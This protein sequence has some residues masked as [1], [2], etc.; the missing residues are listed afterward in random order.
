MPDDTAHPRY[1][2]RMNE[3]DA[4]LWRIERDPSLPTL[5]AGARMARAFP[6]FAAGAVVNPRRAAREALATGLSIGRLVSP[7]GRPLSPLWIER[8]LSRRLDTFDLPLGALK[9]AAHRAGG[10]LNDAYLAGSSAEPAPT[11]NATAPSSTPCASRC[12]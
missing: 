7:V 2:D 8:G 9:D 5:H 4:T 12:R 3:S 10:S 6:A 11:T 1:V